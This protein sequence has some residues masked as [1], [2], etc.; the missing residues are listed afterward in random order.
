MTALTNE[1]RFMKACFC[2]LRRRPGSHSASGCVP[3]SRAAFTLVEVLVV[4]VLVF[5][6]ILASFETML[7]IN[8]NS[9]RV[10]D[11]S[12]ATSIAQ[13]K[14]EEIRAATYNP[15][16]APFTAGTNYLTNNPGICLSKAGTNYLL[17]GV[18]I[19]QISP[20]A[21]GHLVTVTATFT[22]GDS[23]LNPTITVTLQS[24]VNSFT[25]GQNPP[26]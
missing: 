3:C 15:P 7:Y 8:F 25:G 1:L 9:H 2:P 16:N 11:I 20:T 14:L 6:L 5:M 21:E 12:A 10:A 23:K 22:N 18:V 17:P 13:A 26:P 4:T 24:L 19:S